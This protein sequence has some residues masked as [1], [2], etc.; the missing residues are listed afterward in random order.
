MELQALAQYTHERDQ[1]EA[2]HFQFVINN[3]LRTSVPELCF[4]SICTPSWPIQ[5]VLCA[6]PLIVSRVTFKS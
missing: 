6:I 1:V 4:Y 5:A 3:V 2:F